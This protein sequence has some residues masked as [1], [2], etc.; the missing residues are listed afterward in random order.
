MEAIVL[1]VTAAL[2]LATSLLIRLCQKLERR[3]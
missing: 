3:S 2:V 1:A